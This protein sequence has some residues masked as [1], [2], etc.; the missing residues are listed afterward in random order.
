MDQDNMDVVFSRLY[1]WM[2]RS[3]SPTLAK[4]RG[5]ENFM[6]NPFSPARG[7]YNL[8]KISI[9]NNKKKNDHSIQTYFITHPSNRIG[10]EFLIGIR[11]LRKF[12]DIPSFWITVLFDKL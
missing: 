3:G 1:P 11:Y 7:H 6:K 10:Y 8:S 4:P 12:S 9:D 5:R 2:D